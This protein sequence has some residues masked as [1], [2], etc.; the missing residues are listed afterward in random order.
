VVGKNI[1]RANEPAAKS[2][3]KPKPQP[4]TKP[5]AVEGQDAVRPFLT[6]SLPEWKADEGIWACAGCDHLVLSLCLDCGSE[7]TVEEHGKQR[8]VLCGC[9]VVRWTSPRLYLPKDFGS[10]V[11]CEC[12]NGWEWPLVNAEEW[13]R[14]WLPM[15]LVE[16]PELVAVPRSRVQLKKAADRW[17]L[18]KAMSADACKR[19]KLVEANCADH[20]SDAEYVQ[21]T[22]CP[23]LVSTRVVTPLGDCSVDQPAGLVLATGG[24]RDDHVIKTGDLITFDDAPSAPSLVAEPVVEKVLVEPIVVPAP[25]NGS[26]KT[27]S[28]RERRQRIK[29]AFNKKPL[30]APVPNEQ[31][32]TPLP[33]QKVSGSGAVVETAKLRVRRNRLAAVFPNVPTGNGWAVEPSVGY[34]KVAVEEQPLNEQVREA[35]AQVAEAILVE[36]AIVRDAKLLCHCGAGVYIACPQCLA[37]LC[38]EHVSDC[39]VCDQKASGNESGA[40]EPPEITR[41]P[42]LISVGL[43][44]SQI[45]E[46][47]QMPLSRG[48]LETS[49]PTLGL[50]RPSSMLSAS[51]ALS[52]GSMRGQNYRLSGLRLLGKSSDPT[53]VG[54]KGG[55]SLSGQQQQAQQFPWLLPVVQPSRAEVL[56]QQVRAKQELVDELV[57]EEVERLRLEEPSSELNVHLEKAAQVVAY[58]LRSSGADSFERLPINM[59]GSPQREAGP[60]GQVNPHL[61]VSSGEKI[62]LGKPLLNGVSTPVLLKELVAHLRKQTQGGAVDISK[63]RWLAT[64]AHR[65]FETFDVAGTT[66]S[67]RVDW[68]STAISI[69]AKPD[70]GDL[71]MW[72]MLTSKQRQRA[73]TRWTEGKDTRWFSGVRNWHARRNLSRKADWV[74]GRESSWLDWFDHLGTSA[75][76]LERDFVN[77]IRPGN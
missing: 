45:G 29:E 24:V 66:E 5:A 58:E 21:D 77:T 19:Y 15:I 51:R 37:A 9:G 10:Q 30:I 1:G 13:F 2:Q 35:I 20:R 72:Q 3:A 12:S 36:D 34:V 28:R 33:L 27:A 50:T 18:L 23:T 49:T 48:C 7:F 57:D 46:R 73:N 53:F 54:L 52:T 74:E 22:G 26:K 31:V 76:P 56:Q 47:H 71:E 70:Q 41:N 60:F 39:S 64:I 16:T 55:S 63:T 14:Q 75:S 67:Q 11:G 32:A 61:P 8:A 6:A 65:W 42:K 17:P 68:V 40:R 44:K 38:E 43:P 59:L 69:V 62:R 25:G 4:P